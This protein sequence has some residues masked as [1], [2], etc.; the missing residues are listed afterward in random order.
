MRFRDGS[1]LSG[2]GS[3][4]GMAPFGPLYFRHGT[5]RRR[6]LSELKY[7]LFRTGLMNVKPIHPAVAAATHPAPTLIVPDWPA[8][9]AVRA[10]FTTRRGG[11]SVGPWASLNLATHVGDDGAAAASNRA[12]LQHWLGLE[13]Q[14]RWLEQ[15]HSTTVARFDA[16]G[17]TVPKADAA[18]TTCPGLA[19]A[20]LVADCVPVLLCSDDGAEVAAVH[21]G[22]RGLDGGVLARAVAAFHAPPH[23]LLAWIGP[24]IGASA[25]R[26]GPELVQ[27]FATRDSGSAA[28]FRQHD[29][30]WQL[31]LH[32][33]TRR[34]LA[35]AGVGAI[36][37]Q[38]RCVYAEP[39]EFF[40]YRRDGVTGRMAA[41]IWIM[42]AA[43]QRAA[44]A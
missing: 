36:H 12:R 10:V 22:W 37:G 33:L 41:L 9:A 8:P 35:A 6:G 11:T 31:D 32:A 14:P 38:P 19:C 43:D 5:R 30:A 2:G 16:P 28:C 3:R 4:G 13:S 18:V 24:C 29:D 20:V 23:R 40:S 15:V 21:A 17:A 42:N 1:G 39:A 44:R 27:R 34:Q 26:V 25:Y 7:A